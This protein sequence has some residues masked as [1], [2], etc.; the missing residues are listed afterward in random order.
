MGALEQYIHY[1]NSRVLPC[2]NIHQSYTF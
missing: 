1:N 2:T